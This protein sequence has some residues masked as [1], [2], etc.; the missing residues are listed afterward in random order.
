M[1]AA[2]AFTQM[3]SYIS[4]HRRTRTYS[5]I[6]AM[7]YNTINAFVWHAIHA[8]YL[9]PQTLQDNGEIERTRLM[10]NNLRIFVVNIS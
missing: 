4:M 2:A 1:P 9:L 10:R 6:R 5:L 7:P 3:A 8:Y